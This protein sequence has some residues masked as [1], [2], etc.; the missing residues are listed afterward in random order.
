[1]RNLFCALL[2]V[3][4]LAAEGALACSCMP[5]PAPPQALAK[6]DAVFFG[7]AVKVVGQAGPHGQGE[8]TVSFEVERFWKGNVQKNLDLGTAAHGALCGYAFR[9]GEN[10]LVYAYTDPLGGLRTTLCSRTRLEADADEDFNALGDGE[11]P[12]FPAEAFTDALLATN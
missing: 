10:Y 11:T 3:L 1:M 8:V 12:S 9:Q 6:A 2:L 7:K 5:P 4:A